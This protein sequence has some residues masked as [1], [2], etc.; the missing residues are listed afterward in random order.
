MRL[1]ISKKY[2]LFAVDKNCEERKLH[3]YIDDNKFMEFDIRLAEGEAKYYFPMDV[4]NYFGR[5]I[6]IRVGCGNSESI[7]CGDGEETAEK[8][9]IE[10]DADEK[11]L[12]A[13][14]GLSDE[15]PRLDYKYRPRLHFT[16]EMGWINDPNGLIYKD[17][18]FHMYYQWNPYGIDWGNMHWGHAVSKNL[19]DWER[20]DTALTPD[21]YGTVYSG[22]AFSDDKNAAGFGAGS[23]I[24]FY[25]ASGGRNEWSA[26]KGRK[27]VQRIA[28]SNDNGYTLRKKCTVVEHIADENRDPKVFW[29]EESKAYIMILYLEGNDFV[30]LRSDDLIH[31]KESC[32]FTADK[33]W[34]CPD[35]FK[36]KVEGS[37]ETKWVFWSADGYYMIG[38]FDGYTF[39]K[40]SNVLFAYGSKLGYAA[41]TFAGIDDRCISVAWL[42]TENDKGGFRGMMAIPMEMSLKRAEKGYRINIKPVRELWDRFKTVREYK[43]IEKSEGFE[44]FENFERFDRFEEK[45]NDKP[46]AIVVDWNDKPQELAENTEDV[47]GTR[48]GMDENYC[49]MRDT[50]GMR[51]TTDSKRD[52]IDEFCSKIKNS[53]TVTTKKIRIGDIDLDVI[54]NDHKTV[55]IIDNGIITY[56]SNDGER[57]T[58]IEAPEDILSKNLFIEGMEGIVRIYE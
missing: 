6:D 10:S 15:K 47:E 51:N 54:E 27:H 28:V 29:H 23:I 42:R 20:L 24:Y 7:T 16:A 12:K 8:V 18:L 55:I 48:I 32:K 53:G 40:E 25:T 37:D 41:Q 50:T 57:Y 9:D 21:D 13:S 46:V 43:I 11:V 44:K 3:F 35:L 5:V 45:L 39:K 49:N 36:L 30:I 58:E 22:C 4:S 1:D 14:V 34:E 2:I 52:S 33:M 31:W 17:G 38:E 26:S 56:I 19:I